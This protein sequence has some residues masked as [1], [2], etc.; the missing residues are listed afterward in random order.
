[1]H[2]A[3]KTSYENQVTFVGKHGQLL[4]NLRVKKDNE[5]VKPL[6]CLQGKTPRNLVPF[7]NSV[8]SRLILGGPWLDVD[9]VT[10]WEL[11]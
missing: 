4:R 10:D 11:L 5:N 1:M 3:W 8:D 9:Q 6:V 2:H 7:L